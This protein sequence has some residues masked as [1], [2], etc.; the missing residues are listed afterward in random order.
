MGFACGIKLIPSLLWGS[1]YM[2]GTQYLITFNLACILK[3]SASLSI[4]DGLSPSHS[5]W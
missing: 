5:Q 2:P 4:T 1:V 3:K